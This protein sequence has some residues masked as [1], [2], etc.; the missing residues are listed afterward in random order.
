MSRSRSWQPVHPRRSRR[1][2]PAAIWAD[3]GIGDFC[4]CRSGSGAGGSA[5]FQR[6]PEA[7][8][9]PG[10]HGYSGAD[11]DGNAGG[12]RDDNVRVVIVN[13]TGRAHNAALLLAH[14]DAMQPDD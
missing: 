2:R 10:A 7:F 3:T 12:T 6:N 13:A 8:L 9:H 11:L 5:Y 14:P 4:R 1:R